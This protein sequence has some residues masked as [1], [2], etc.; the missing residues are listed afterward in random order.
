MK[1][2]DVTKGK[3]RFCGPAAISA[4]T[5]RPVDEVV[6]AFHALFPGKKVMGTHSWELTRVLD[7]YGLTVRPARLPAK[8]TL[9]RWLRDNKGNRTPGRV[10]LLA[11]ARHWVVVSGRRI[12]CGKVMQIMSVRDYPHRRGRVTEVYEITGTQGRGTPD[13]VKAH[14]AVKAKKKRAASKEGAYRA[15]IR[16]LAERHGIDI[17][18]DEYTSTIWVYPPE[19]LYANEGDDPYD[20][21]HCAAYWNEVEERVNRYVQDIKARPATDGASGCTA[22]EGAPQ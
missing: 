22:A 17:D 14:R 15:K 20:D 2:H 9:A 10:F 6:D 12:V 11:S 1:I 16:T 18:P 13:I 8:V 4:I 21:E 5:G 3:N 7:H 19:G